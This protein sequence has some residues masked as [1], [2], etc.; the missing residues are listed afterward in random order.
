MRIPA[1]ITELKIKRPDIT[2]IFYF[3]KG[4]FILLEITGKGIE[5][6]CYKRDDPEAWE[7]L[8]LLDNED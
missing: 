7:Y 3:D 6:Q 5:Y 1:N 8:K 2:Y 4:L